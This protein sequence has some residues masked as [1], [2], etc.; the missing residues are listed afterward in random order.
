[1]IL[2]VKTSN[3]NGH[4]DDLPVK[5]SWR[6][7]EGVEGLHFTVYASEEK[8]RIAA[9]KWATPSDVQEIWITEEKPVDDDILFM[10][11]S[12]DSLGAAH[13]FCNTTCYLLNSE[14]RN[15]QKLI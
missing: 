8:L 5:E 4:L 13:I 9:S 11:F 14:G 7:Y 10:A 1:M 12:S 2:K 6:F 3:A 15:I